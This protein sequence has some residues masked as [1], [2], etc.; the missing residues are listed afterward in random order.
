M[1]DKHIELL[2]KAVVNM[3]FNETGDL[4]EDC[5]SAGYKALDIL[6]QALLPALD[7]VGT[8]FRDGDYF[9][10]DVLMSVKAYNTAYRLIEEELKSGN[11]ESRGKVLIGTVQGDIHEIGKNILLALCQGNGFDIVDLGKDVPP[12]VFLEKAREAKPDIIGMSALLTTTMPVMK[13]VL[14][15]FTEAGIRD[16]YKFIVGGAPVSRGFAEEIGADGYGGDAQSG[17]E[18]IK[19][20]LGQ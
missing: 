15:T 16:Q 9:L 13:D 10:P 14:D 4:T 11:Y 5:R 2:R 1:S 7:Q 17:V 12:A 18:L 6:N 19:K 20:I 8:L 3:R